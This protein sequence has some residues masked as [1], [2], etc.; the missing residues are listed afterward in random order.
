MC[1]A[2]SYSFHLPALNDVAF[3]ATETEHSIFEF[4]GMDGFLYLIS[5][6]KKYC[7]YQ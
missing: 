3:M 1:C 4:V 2:H 6:L 7:G 5:F